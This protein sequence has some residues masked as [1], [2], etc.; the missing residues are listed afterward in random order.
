MKSHT[1][2]EIKR[3]IEKSLSTPA[4]ITAP[5]QLEAASTTEIS[6]IGK[7]KIRKISRYQPLL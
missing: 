2:N 4:S 7:Q 6:F 3:T 5:E 1:I